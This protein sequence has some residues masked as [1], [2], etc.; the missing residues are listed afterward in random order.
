ME[1]DGT[2]KYALDE[3]GIGIPFP[4]VDVHMKEG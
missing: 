2:V 3:A 1:A 4:Q